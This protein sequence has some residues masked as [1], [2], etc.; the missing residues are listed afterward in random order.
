M[1]ARR[2]TPEPVG[3][4]AVSAWQGGEA[5]RAEVLTAVRYTLE[6][7]AAR[8]PGGAVEVRVPPAGVVQIGV[9]DGAG[10]AE[11]GRAVEPASAASDGRN[12]RHTRGTPPAVVETTCD[13]WLRLA[14]GALAWDDAVD[15]GAVS[16][17]GRRAILRDL[18]P[19]VD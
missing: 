9:A 5:S 11:A 1:P 19:V 10:G 4:A 18:L 12:P 7:L 15:S 8:N 13:V 17:S 16:A 2:R 6:E 14:T 3:R